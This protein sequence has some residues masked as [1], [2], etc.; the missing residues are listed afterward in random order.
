MRPALVAGVLLALAC[1]GAPTTNVQTRSGPVQFQAGNA[2]FVMSGAAIYPT[3]TLP[4]GGTDFGTPLEGTGF[5]LTIADAAWNCW[6]ASP[7]PPPTTINALNWEVI[8]LNTGTVPTGSY[9][10]VSAFDPANPVGSTGGGYAERRGAC[11]SRHEVLGGGTVSIDHLDDQ[12]AQ[13]SVTV[14]LD[15]GTRIE[16]PFVARRCDFI[17]L[18]IAMASE[19]ALP[20]P[21]CTS[22]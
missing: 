10:A 19:G 4:D 7:G 1:G 12:T 2:R 17:G 5:N 9:A 11:L 21:P 20:L 14:T 13:G 3:T 16:G 18:Q 15:D 6:D 8:R 22:P